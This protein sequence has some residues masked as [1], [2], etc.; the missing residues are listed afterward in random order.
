[1]KKLMIMMAAI[2]TGAM[3]WAASLTDPVT[4]NKEN[5]ATF[6]AGYNTFVGYDDAGKKQYTESSAIVHWWMPGF[7]IGETEDPLT[8]AEIEV[9][10]ETEPTTAKVLQLESGSESPVL[11]TFAAVAPGGTYDAVDI[12]DHGTFVDTWVKLSASEGALE[13]QEGDKI[14][15]WLQVVEEETDDQ[16]T[17]TVP[18]ATNLVVTCG[19][20]N[21]LFEPT[22]TNVVLDT[23]IEPDTWHR[24]TIRAMKGIAASASYK[25][26]GFL[27]YIDGTIVAAK[28]DAYLDFTDVE[29]SAEVQ[30]YAAARQLFPSL[31]QDEAATLT[32]AGFSGVGQIASVNL[33]TQHSAPYFAKDK[34]FIRITWDEHVRSIVL[35][36]GANMVTPGVAGTNDIEIASFAPTSPFVSPLQTLAIEY[37]NTFKCDSITGSENLAT[38]NNDPDGDGKGKAATFSLHEYANGQIDITSQLDRQGAELYV[39]KGSTSEFEKFGT[40]LP[41][42]KDIIGAILAALG[43]EE[44]TAED[45]VK[46]V[47][48]EDEVADTTGDWSEITCEVIFDLNGHSL[49]AS[50]NWTGGWPQDYDIHNYAVIGNIGNLMIMDG[51]GGGAIIG[52]G[53]SRGL[54]GAA[55]YNGGTLVIGESAGEVITFTGLVANT[56]EGEAPY[57]Q[58]LGG[59]YTDAVPETPGTVKLGT[60]AAPLC[61][62]APATE[63]DYYT[64]IPMVEFSIVAPTH[65]TVT[66][67]ADADGNEIEDEDFIDPNATYTVTITADSGYVWGTDETVTEKTENFV[68]AHDADANGV[69]TLKTV[70]PHEAAAKV[71]SYTITGTD[72]AILAITI[73]G[74]PTEALTGNVVVGNTLTIVAT[75]AEGY[76]YDGNEDYGA[77]WNWNDEDKSWTFTKT[78]EKDAPISVTIKQAKAITY[79]AQVGNTKYRTLAEAINAA[80]ADQTV[81]LL[82]NITLTETLTIAKQTAINLDGCTVTFGDGLKNGI[83][84]TAAAANLVISNGYFT[85]AGTRPNGGFAFQ[86]YR[87]NATIKDVEMDLTGFEYGLEAETMLDPMEDNWTKQL[88]Y[89]ITCK[90][91]DVTG[92]GSLFHFE[93]V[94]ATLDDECS[95]TLKAG[96]TPFG[97]A[98][99]A[100]IYSSC[101]AKVTVA[102][103]NYNYSQQ[104][105]LQTGDLGGTLIVNGGTF[106]GDIKS[107]MGNREQR[108]VTEWAANIGKITITGGTF[109]GNFVEV[110]PGSEKTV[111]DIK[112]GTFSADPTKYLA[113]NYATIKNANDKWDV[114]LAIIATFMVDSEIYTAQT[115]I[116]AFLPATPIAPEKPNYAFTGWDPEIDMI[117][118]SE[119]YMAQFSANPATLTLPETA[120][121]VAT[122]TV[123]ES[124][125]GKATWKPVTIDDGAYPI[126]A[127]SFYKVAVTAA[128]HYELKDPAVDAIISDAAVTP[129]AAITIEAEQLEALVQLHSYNITYKQVNEQPITGL[130]PATF[131][132]AVAVELPTDLGA[133][134]GGTFKGWYANA[135]LTGDPITGWAAGE[136]TDNVTVYAKI[137]KVVDEPAEIVKDKVSVPDDATDEQKKAIHDNAQL[138]Y[139]K[140][141][142]VELA[143]AWIASVY[144]E[145][146]KIPGAKLAAASAEN[147]KIAVEY[148]I[149]IMESP[150]V[151]FTTAATPTEGNAAA[152]TFQIKDGASGDPISLEAAETAGKVLSMV[153]YCSTL[154]SWAPATSENVEVSV[155]DDTAKVELVKK[156]GVAAGFMKVVLTPPA[157]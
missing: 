107:F 41:Y 19:A 10:G 92:N 130:N 24:I 127:G 153:Q 63:E 100:A 134:L 112:G 25:N 94:E 89:T 11:R 75:A 30:K 21:S 1:M 13:A 138:I 65:T 146:V 51:E 133:Q 52:R 87:V 69:I 18:A 79:V 80:T 97:A 50:E 26:I 23:D 155:D 115:N 48:L 142:T 149:E 111:W 88:L 109:D 73:D 124:D 122:M 12:E 62:L 8:V 70:A 82:T 44:I 55:V 148:C 17:V 5:L 36:D 145:G 152:F 47:L 144:G 108:S 113:A 99:N 119:T 57:M 39:Q 114:G 95:A 28:E 29:L 68:F 61:W 121:G 35:G 93:N 102:G 46:I 83:V 4:Y 33:D 105:A 81:T 150:V 53:D 125:D 54:G 77:G 9:A 137:E 20:L 90:N 7:V 156:N 132:I 34:T 22:K 64:L 59:Q 123:Y 151:T 157:E 76:E 32:A 85:V 154:G 78:A 136:Q 141:G 131:T 96:S 84:T 91:V 103:G 14:A 71:V 37:V 143:E 3:A 31:Q 126:A 40:P 2:A 58:V 135:E 38:F 129:G 147:V 15:V 45:T 86:L 140:F 67:I 43:S 139:T 106:T 66:A 120:T 27:V 104:V 116:E 117:E 56:S 74:D 128:Q 98:H 110:V 6:E 60:D 49:T 42:V 72:T 16:G 101:G 118:E